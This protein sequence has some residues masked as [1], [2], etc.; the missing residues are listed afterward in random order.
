MWPWDE[1][2]HFLRFFVFFRAT[3]KISTRAGSTRS[4]C[5]QEG[6]SEEGKCGPVVRFHT[7][8]VRAQAPPPAA[9]PRDAKSE[10]RPDCTHGKDCTGL[11]T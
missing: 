10:L 3:A 8:W 6:A 11:E 4:R 1:G 7:F 5:T 2:L 9:L